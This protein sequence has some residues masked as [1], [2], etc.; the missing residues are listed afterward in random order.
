M[1]T[2]TV[3]QYYDGQWDGLEG[4]SPYTW[5]APSYQSAVDLKGELEEEFPDRVWSITEKDVS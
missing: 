1:K 5:T 2:E 3:E 4:E